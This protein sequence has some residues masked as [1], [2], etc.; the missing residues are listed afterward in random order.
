ML[1]RMVFIEEFFKQTVV[2]YTVGRGLAPA[3][4]AFDECLRFRYLSLRLLRRQLPHQR[5]PERVSESS[6]SKQTMVCIEVGR[7]LALAVFAF[8]E[9][10]RFRYLSLSLL[11]R[12][13]PHQREPERVSGHCFQK[14]RLRSVTM[15][16][17][18]SILVW[19]ANY[20]P[21]PL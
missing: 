9:C 2:C 6:F 4:F 16:G 12:Q 15:W 7:G 20:F 10:L 21:A 5:E 1:R 18:I 17:I 13:L 8:G 14:N 19:H 3:V 11:H